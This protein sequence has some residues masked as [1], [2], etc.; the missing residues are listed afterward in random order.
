MYSPTIIQRNVERLE[1]ELKI[2][3][4]RYEPGVCL[5]ARDRLDQIRK[6][7]G[8]LKRPFTKAE[9][10]FIRNECLLSKLDFEYWCSRYATIDRDGVEGGGLGRLNL[11]ESQRIVLD[12]IALAEEEE[13]R[14]QEA[15]QP[16]DGIMMLF[17][18]AR[19]EGLTGICRALTMHRLTMWHNTRALAASVDDDKIKEL[20]DRDKLIY[21]CGLEKEEYSLK[22]G[23]PYWMRPILNFDVKGAHLDFSQLGSRILYQFSTMGS[24][25]GQGRQFDIGHM[26]E[27]AYWAEDV[28]AM[29]GRDFFPTLPQSPRTLFLAESVSFGR[30]GWWY[31]MSKAIEAHRLP[32]WRFC[33]I[34]WYAIT[35]KYRR[36]PASDWVPDEITQRHADMVWETSIDYLGRRIRLDREQMYWWESTREEYR[37]N[38]ELA[39][40]LTNYCATP[41]EGHQHSNP[42]AISHETLSRLHDEA[43]AHK[44]LPYLLRLGSTRTTQD[45]WSHG[46]IPS[47]QV[48]NDAIVPA[49]PSE[50]DHDARGIV[51]L[52][53][54]PQTTAQYIMGID[55]TN[56]IIPW[57]RNIRREGDT[58]TDNGCIQILRKGADE[59]SPDVQVAEF[60]A[61]MDQE[62]LAEVANLL[63]R[64]FG[65]QQED[66]EALCI[67]EIHLAL[68]LIVNRKLMDLGYTNLWVWE[69]IDKM[70]IS[71]TGHIGWY[72]SP[73][74]VR[75][76]WE[77]FRRRVTLNG[78][79]IRSRWLVEELQ[80]CIW[81]HHK[82]TA[83][84]ASGTHDDR[85]RG[86]ALCE[87]AAHSWGA[88]ETL[89]TKESNEKSSKVEWQRSAVTWEQ[90]EEQMNEI[91]ES[92]FD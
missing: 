15:G 36:F 43:A 68:G 20:Y 12:K 40:F 38:N 54:T 11:W 32:R 76:L 17:N 57:N 87:W 85:I 9:Q 67:T 49:H 89:S 13:Y 45:D 63:G 27:L 81:D 75:T 61:P 70:A 53:E 7:D 42:T 52:W 62:S 29:L 84:A 39:A 48:G 24:A 41:E 55:P 82:Q 83:N 59:N 4:K 66:G 56:G 77:Q 19:Q 44:P 2:K 26:T 78:I 35:K 60:A 64:I 8:S 46:K 30:T 51:W 25:I 31:R 58:N 33:F 34:P 22:G 28:L 88:P 47:F 5:E 79:K 86:L 18:K 23:L 92:W 69:H 72:A 3:L 71:Q 37:Q 10:E 73:T 21:N 50:I 16:C 14:K 6:P 1:A 90:Q 91:V 65:G 74:A 80:D